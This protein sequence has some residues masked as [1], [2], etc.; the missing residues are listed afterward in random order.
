MNDREGLEH[1]PSPLTHDIGYLI[2]DLSFSNYLICLIILSLYFD[3]ISHYLISH[4]FYFKLGLFVGMISEDEG[5][6]IKHYLE[7]IS[8]SISDND[9]L[10]GMIGKRKR[11]RFL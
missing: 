7:V 1:I 9:D 2:I 5:S 6:L 3:L 11:E 10:K 8:S 4:I